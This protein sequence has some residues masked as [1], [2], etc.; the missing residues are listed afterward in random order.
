[1]KNILLLVHDDD[2][3]EARFQ[4]ALDV[5]RAVNGHL[6]CLDVAIL[7]ALL[8]DYYSGAGEAML[9]ADER[10]RESANKAILEERLRHEDVPWDWVDTCGSL[11]SCVSEAARMAD[12][13][14][15]NRKLESF[16]LPDM[17][18][19]ASG[20]LVESHKP[21]LAVPEASRALDLAGRALV[22]WDGS[23]AAMAA[24]RAAVPL[25]KL[26]ES[27]TLLEID[28]GSVKIP[29]E[30]A[31]SYLSREDIHALVRREHL[32]QHSAPDRLCAESRSGQFA[33]IVMG[34]FGH[35]RLREAL[36]GGVTRRLLSESAVPLLLA[37]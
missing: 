13:I 7:P 17:L 1:V 8:T 33:Y 2:G 31:A 12:L 28:D 5:V 30:E 9:L 29:A 34:G 23:P 15:V 37:H 4:A 21:I 25:L 6:S 18:D 20:L 24:M 32:G 26:A 19:A 36:F 10:A 14:V 22:A 11:V 16:P 27:V 3:Q 35:S